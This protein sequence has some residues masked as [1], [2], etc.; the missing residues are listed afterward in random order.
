MVQGEG[1]R[2]GWCRIG[3]SLVLDDLTGIHGEVDMFVEHKLNT[4]PV[5]RPIGDGYQ[6]VLTEFGERLEYLFEFDLVR[7]AIFVKLSF[8]LEAD[9]SG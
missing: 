8:E 2:L 9:E 6:S 5:T 1:S 7:I 4:E 3:K